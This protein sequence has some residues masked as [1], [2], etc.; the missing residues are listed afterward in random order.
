MALDLPAPDSPEMTTRSSR[1]DKECSSASLT[2]LAISATRLVEVGVKVAGD[3]LR[4]T[5]DVLEVLSRGA[6]HRLGR[7]EVLQQ[8]SLARRADARQLVH[9][10]L[11]HRLVAAGTVMGDGKA[12]RLVAHPLQQLQL[13]R[14]VGQHDG[15]RA[16]RGE[17]LLDALGQ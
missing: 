11:G 9:D 17:D 15:I 16:A 8:G 10:R 4:E 6:E 12:V 1:L 2:A 13:G 3:L 7:A 5:G 14:L